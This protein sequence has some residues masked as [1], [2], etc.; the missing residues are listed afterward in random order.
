ML[1]EHHNSW[2]QHSALDES[3]KENEEEITKENHFL[4]ILTVQ[5]MK[6]QR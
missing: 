4:K 2:E 3:R 1:K 6:G 5:C